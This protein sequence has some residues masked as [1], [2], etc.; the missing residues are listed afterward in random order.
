[1][2]MRQRGFTLVEI[3]V[4]VAIIGIM[5]AVVTLSV[6]LAFGDRDLET[7]RDRLLALADHLRDQAALQN[8]EY[9][10]RCFDGGYQFLVYDARERVWTNGEDDLLRARELP[11]GLELKLWIEGQP[12]ALPSADMEEGE[13]LPQVLLYSS[14]DLNLFELEL[15]RKDGGA[16]VRLSPAIE[17]SDRILMTMLPPEPQ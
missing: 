11:E 2:A 4:V 13:L 3:L 6:G 1:M 9:G 15:R 16:G 12:V 10:L 5:I 14:G 8:R 17:A 7:E